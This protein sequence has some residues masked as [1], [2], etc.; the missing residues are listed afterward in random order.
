MRYLNR[1]RYSRIG[2]H[3]EDPLAGVANLFDASIV[4]IVAMMLALFSAWN[5]MDLLDPNSEV[6]IA[7]KSADGHVE[8]LTKKGAEIKVSKV[9][10]KPLSGSG[11]RLGTA[12][13]LP[14]GKVVYVPE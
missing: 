11:K 10:D 9:S 2:E 8:V 3:N 4:F 7:K 14:D 1:H 13:Q 6:T 12:Y 5:M